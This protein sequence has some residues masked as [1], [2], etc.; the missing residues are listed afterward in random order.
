MTELVASRDRT[1]GHPQKV[2]SLVSSYNFHP[3][4][5]RRAEEASIIH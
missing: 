4:G 2:E 5:H 1:L 3:D